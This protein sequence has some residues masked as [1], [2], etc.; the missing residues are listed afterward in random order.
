MKLSV[1]YQPT[2]P[3]S[4]SPYRV[5]DEQGRELDWANAFLDGQRI[6]QLSACS[7]RIYAYDLLDFARWFEPQHQPLAEITESTLVDYVRHQLDIA[8]TRGKKC[9]PAKCISS[10]AIPNGSRLA[11]VG[12]AMLSREASASNK[13]G[14]SSCRSLRKKSRSS[15]KVSAPIAIWL[16]WA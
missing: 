7:L 3:A 12:P 10:A 9:P 14:G 6:R 11:A 5:R 13:I 16:W 15:G 1:I 2:V 4:T 8:F